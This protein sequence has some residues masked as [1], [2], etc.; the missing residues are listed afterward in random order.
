MIT[1]S[2]SRPKAR[3]PHRCGYCNRVIDPGETYDRQVNIAD[4]RVY[5]WKSCLHCLALVRELDVWGWHDEGT[6]PDDIAETEPR[7]IFEARCLVMWRRKWRRK[8]DGSLYSIPK[9]EKEN[10]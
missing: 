1:L 2:D 3:K 5:T 8:T 9:R 7:D 4:D 6:G 10:A